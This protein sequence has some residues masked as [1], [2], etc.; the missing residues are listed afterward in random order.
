MRVLLVHSLFPVTY[1][2]FQDTLRL[3]G[4]EAS[5]PPLGLV[6]L[7]ACLPKSWELRLVDL[8][9]QLLSDSDVRWAD[10]VFVGGMFVQSESMLEVLERA[11]EHNRPV[12][13]GGPAATTT[14]ELFAEAEVV[15][16]GEAEGRIDALVEAVESCTPGEQ[17][18]VPPAKERPDMT[19]FPVPRF[20]L[21]DLPKYS[22]MAIQYSRGCPFR[23]EFCDIVEMFG[24]VPRVK[25]DEQ[26][27]A[28]LS[29]IERFG[30]KGSVFVV[31]DNFIGN[32]REVRHLLPQIGAWQQAHEWPFDFYTE[33]SI[34]L[35]SDPELMSAMVDVGF[36]SVFV[37][38][39]TP[40][41]EALRD[42]GKSQNLRLNLT[43]AVDTLTRAGLEV[44]GGF[45]VGF[46]T[47][48]PEIFEAQR[49]FIGSSPIPLAMVSILGALPGT[50]LW[51]RLEEEGRLR[52]RPEGDQFGRANFEPTMDEEDL[53]RGYRDL[54]LDLYDPAAYYQRC[55]DYVE[56]TGAV[57]V[58]GCAGLED[59]TYFLKALL[60]VGVQSPRRRLFWKL[61]HRAR[62]APSHAFKWSVVK[63][64][65]GEH[66][67]HYTVEHVVPRLNRAIAEVRAEHDGLA[68]GV[69]RPAAR[70]AVDAP[71]AVPEKQ[72]L[73]AEPLPPLVRVPAVG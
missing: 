27:V 60:R 44:M 18:V 28:E 37:G 26:I 35:A 55:L 10:A 69:G 41:L 68:A 49:R 62:K 2:G 56:K 15:F 47:D 52:G 9:V 64:L 8:N 14:P 38:I 7:A 61:L 45:I 5:L 40:S 63:A 66:M 71:P 57:P 36:R 59:V 16:Q 25:T 39:E 33:A 31:D 70:P 6:S 29:A 12:V 30:F 53:L 20:D 11:H 46:D 50:A 58:S 65:Q 73:P 23:C 54:L 17:I 43:E 42:A 51:R 21:L 1:W 72:N 22:S 3:V 67:I 4:K 32:K 19:S 13:V 48:G 24:H 34:N